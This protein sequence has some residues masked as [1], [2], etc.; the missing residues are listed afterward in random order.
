MLLTA[1]SVTAS[2]ADALKILRLSTTVFKLLIPEMSTPRL[3]KKSPLPPGKHTFRL[4][5]V[6]PRKLKELPKLSGD[7][8]EK[9]RNWQPKNSTGDMIAKTTVRRKLMMPRMVNKKQMKYT[10]YLHLN[11]S[12]KVISKVPMMLSTPKPMKTPKMAVTTM[13]TILMM[14]LMESSTL[15]IV[16]SR[17]LIVSLTPLIE[18]TIV[19]I[20]AV[21]EPN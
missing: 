6:P 2:K 10:R 7:E 17:P 15:V 20:S 18:L 12:Q 4:F 21:L 13:V 3:A 5:A 1:T 11:L 8:M 16:L 19:S 9:L 14:E